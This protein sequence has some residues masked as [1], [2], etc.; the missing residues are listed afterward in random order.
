MGW[1]HAKQILDGAVPSARLSD[2]VEPYFLGPGKN[3]LQAAAF[4]EF[5]TATEGSVWFHE[6][7]DTMSLPLPGTKKLGIIS[8]RTV[9]NPQLLREVKLSARHLSEKK[10]QMLV[11]SLPVLLL[12]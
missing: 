2:I 4:Q 12:S 8:G 6:S 5:R 1:W 10:N 3:D 9:D 7:V 11:P